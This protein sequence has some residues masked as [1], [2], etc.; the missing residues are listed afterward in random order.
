[1][2]KSE[3]A[4]NLPASK[5]AISSRRLRSAVTAARSPTRNIPRVVSRA[6]IF[7]RARAPIFWR[8]D[9]VEFSFRDG[10]M[11]VQLPVEKMTLERNSARDG[12]KSAGGESDELDERYDG[13]CQPKARSGVRLECRAR[14]TGGGGVEVS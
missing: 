9:H 6:S 3:S 11:V 5:S 8:L 4:S 10:L 7:S 1:M 12:R 14:G 13:E 2:A